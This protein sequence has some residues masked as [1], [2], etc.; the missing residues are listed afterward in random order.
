MRLEGLLALITDSDPEEWSQIS[1]GP[2]YRDYLLEVSSSNHRWTEI[3]S[4]H[5]VMV[6]KPDIAIG[7]A[8]GMTWKEDFKEVWANKF[9]D[10]RADGRFVDVFYNGMLVHRDFYVT[11]DG[12]RAKLPLP[13]T[14][15]DLVVNEQYY[16]LIGL[17]NSLSGVSDYESYFRR[18]GLEI[19]EAKW[20]RQ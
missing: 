12:A 3:N 7:I 10:S 20:P 18:A 6:Y 14:R 13:K 17:L 9:P 15:E 8:F 19:G 11:V 2:T 5:T 4:H 1:E 16:R